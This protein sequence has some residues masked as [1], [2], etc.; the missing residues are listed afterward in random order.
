MLESIC[1]LIILV[2]SFA[3]W[4]YFVRIIDETYHDIGLPVH[5]FFETMDRSPRVLSPGDIIQF[6]S[7]TVICE[8]KPFYL[9][10]FLLHLNGQMIEFV[11]ILLFKYQLKI[12]RKLF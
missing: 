2:T 10:Y 8:L 12:G 4:Y 9:C 6:Q 7:V 3:D 5:I 11:L 1:I